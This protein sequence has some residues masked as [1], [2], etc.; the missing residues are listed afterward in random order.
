[1]DALRHGGLVLYVRHTETGP[2]TDECTISNLSVSGE[3]MAR[4]LGAIVRNLRIPIGKV[5]SSPVC[6]VRD[7]ARLMDLGVTVLSDELRNEAIV[8]GTDLTAM[9]MRM[10]AEV[11]EVGAN[12][13]LVSHMH[14]GLR[15]EKDMDLA[16]GETIVFRPDGRTGIPVARVRFEMWFALAKGSIANQ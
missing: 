16:F 11:P 13:L 9:R 8:A 15:T 4:E 2:I 14:G 1:M 5:R 12:T 3:K 6:R 7:T 10:I